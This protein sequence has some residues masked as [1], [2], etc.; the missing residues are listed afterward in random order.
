MDDSFDT[1]IK[2]IRR[3]NSTPE[4]VLSLVRDNPDFL[5]M[6]SS[7]QY[8]PL[9]EAVDKNRLDLAEALIR[10]GANVNAFAPNA[11][12]YNFKTVL[13]LASEKGDLSMVDLLLRNGADPNNQFRDDKTALFYACENNHPKVVERLLDAGAFVNPIDAGFRT[14][15]HEASNRNH[16]QVVHLLLERGADPFVVDRRGNM[17]RSPEC[18]NE[19]EIKLT[20]FRSS[21]MNERYKQ[22]ESAQREYDHFL[23][24]AKV[25]HVERVLERAPEEFH[26]RK[27]E[28]LS[29]FLG[30]RD[31]NDPELPGLVKF[32]LDHKADPNGPHSAETNLHHAKSPAMAQQLLDAGADVGRVKAHLIPSERNDVLQTLLEAGA[33]PNSRSERW[34]TSALLERVERGDHEGVSLLLK[35]GADR[36]TQNREGQQAVHLADDPKMVRLLAQS[37]C[38]LNATDLRGRTALHD[39]KYKP[40]RSTAVAEALIENGFTAFYTKDKQGHLPGHPLCEA[41]RKVAEQKKHL[42][43]HLAQVPTPAQVSAS[44]GQG[45]GVDTPKRRRL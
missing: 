13:C 16:H 23:T 32:L 39:I 28:M 5:E 44:V 8:T 40:P 14:P 42:E 27:T 37:G 25:F 21:T 33:S 22:E 30:K 6:P 35:H 17:P 4:S 38:D 9:M 12:N 3:P 24:H 18:E 26:A 11:Q 20:I 10:H 43:A 15:L 36:A 31:A 45:E 34:G 29:E 19:R 7:K 1:L 2:R 41:H